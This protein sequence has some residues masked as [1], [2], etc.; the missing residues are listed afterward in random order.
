MGGCG[1]APGR[2][3]RR[4]DWLAGA[5]AV[6]RKD[7]RLELRARYALNAL[8]MFVASSLLLATLAVGRD[9][10]GP[11]VAAALLWIVIVF[12]AAVGMGRAFVA[13]EE[14]GTTLLLR[15]H[16]RGS[17]V[18][19]GKLLFNVV[20]VGAVNAAAAAGMVL[21]LGLT[22]ASPALLL[23]VLA[24][25]AVGL[26]GATTLL[27]ALIARTA[28]G[29]TL[30]AVLAF[31]VLVPLFLSAVSATRRA[32]GG[33]PEG[34]WAASVDDLVALGAYAGAVITASVLLFDY[35]WNE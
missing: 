14:R 4:M 25:G 11:G 2:A 16:V 5:W 34:V 7:V 17:A 3:L 35:V 12:A 20:L 23:T 33:V 22:V 1:H 10:V 18:Y 8:G 19:A 9:D 27:S 31:P 15:L 29:G 13:E 6:F 32:F 26:A 24:L 21:V 28:G 30:L